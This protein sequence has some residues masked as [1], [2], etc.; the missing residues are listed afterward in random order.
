MVGGL[1]ASILLRGHN[2]H[3][4]YPLGEVISCFHLEEGGLILLQDFKVIAC[5]NGMCQ[6]ILISFQMDTS[7]D[8]GSF[9]TVY[10]NVEILC[11]YL[12]LCR[13]SR[14]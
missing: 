1:V 2:E 14:A 4:H 7:D 8:F 9:W 13:Y 6:Y 11:E 3:A 12:L 5:W 10:R